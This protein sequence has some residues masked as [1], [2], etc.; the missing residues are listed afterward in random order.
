MRRVLGLAIIGIFFI[1]LG[2]TG[3]GYVKQDEFMPEYQQFKAE[4]AQEHEQI[5]SKVE[6][7]DQKVD[8]Q[9]TALKEEIQEAKNEA[10][11]AS[12]QGDADTIDTAK[13][14]AQEQ[15]S[16]LRAEIE[17]TIQEA[18]DDVKDF[19]KSGD[20]DLREEVN[21]LNQNIQSDLSE[22]NV[23]LNQ[24]GQMIQEVKQ[25]AKKGVA[26]KVATVYFASGKSGLSDDAK[27]KLDD[28]VSKIKSKGTD[29]MVKVVG[30][31][32]ARPVLSGKYRSNLDLSYA[33]AKSVK[34]YLVEV[35][36]THKIKV[37]ARGHA[38]P[39]ATPDSMKGQKEN[40][41]VEVILV[42][43]E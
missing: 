23:Q 42:A 15:D 32:D 16:E 7:V 28:A 10:I 22:I 30:H 24:G 35:G 12:E 39:I 37:T 4:N 18:K 25:M 43:S 41:R 21:E 9:E 27:A 1:S 33:R 17:D 34:D 3:C 29:W 2:L 8:E 19:S 20:Q 14:F 36:I 5:S 38:E 13:S 26:D 11:A 6:Q 31:A 40:R